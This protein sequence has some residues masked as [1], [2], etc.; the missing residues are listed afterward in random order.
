MHDLLKFANAM[1]YSYKTPNGAL[2]QET[3]RLFWTPNEL[4]KPG[5]I[6]DLPVSLRRS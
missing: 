5:F 1:L 4:T 2:K 3:M 6:T